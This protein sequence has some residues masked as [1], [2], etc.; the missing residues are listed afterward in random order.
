MDKVLYK[1]AKILHKKRLL[2]L[3]I[4]HNKSDAFNWDANETKTIHM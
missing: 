4:V 3:G 1:Y 2:D